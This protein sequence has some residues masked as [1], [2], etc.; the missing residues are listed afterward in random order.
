M[1][2]HG[3]WAD[4][5]NTMHVSTAVQ[6]AQGSTVTRATQELLVGAAGMVITKPISGWWSPLPPPLSGHD[7]TMTF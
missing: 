5:G 6:S 2:V 3:S 1:D 7:Q 4:A